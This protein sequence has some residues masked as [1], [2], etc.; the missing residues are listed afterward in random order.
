MAERSFLYSFCCSTDFTSASRSPAESPSGSPERR[1]PNGAERDDEASYSPQWCLSPAVN[2]TL[3]QEVEASGVSGKRTASKPRFSDATDAGQYRTERSQ[4]TQHTGTTSFRSKPKVLAC[5]SRRSSESL[6]V[7]AI[8]E[9]AGEWW[10]PHESAC[11]E[12][13]DLLQQTWLGRLPKKSRFRMSTTGLIKT[14]VSGWVRRRVSGSRHRFTENGFDLDLAY[15]TSRLIAMG[16][17]GRGYGACFRNPQSEVKRFLNEAHGKKFRIYNLCA[18]KY[19]RD[20]GFPEESV[21]FPSADHC[22][23]DFANMFEF[24]KDVEAWLQADE[25]NVAVVHCKAGKG[26]SGTMICALLLYAE[27]VTSARDALR[28]FGRIRGG[29]RI[30]VTIPSQIRWIAMFEIWLQGC[31]QLT[32]PPMQL[33]DVR[34]RPTSLL[35]GPLRPD[36]V[37][38]D[39]IFMKVGLG[40]RSAPEGFRWVHWYPTVQAKLHDGTCSCSLDGFWWAERDGVICV[41]LQTTKSWFASKQRVCAWWHHSF[42]QRSVEAETNREELVLDLPKTCIDGLQRDAADHTLAPA[43]FRLTVRFDSQK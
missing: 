5:Q 17:P 18:E 42:L 25:E 27:A 14:G 23:P 15:V 24:C 28:W 10:L 6:N 38:Q 12:D 32:S 22:P 20:N 30:G 13:C 4:H 36:M 1:A 31:V 3:H 8:F 33:G 11:V 2:E 43:E 37:L 9:L 7:L 35:V 21:S 34:Y 29:N 16:F 39:S 40:S 41:R 19:F 26:R